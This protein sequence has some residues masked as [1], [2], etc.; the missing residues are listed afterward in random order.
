MGMRSGAAQLL[1]SEAPISALALEGFDAAFRRLKL[2]LCRTC[3]SFTVVW[4]AT[5]KTTLICVNATSLK[6][7]HYLHARE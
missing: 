7:A 4:L 3:L 5:L 2:R 6:R 1:R